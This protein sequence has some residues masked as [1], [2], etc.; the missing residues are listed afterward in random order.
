MAFDLD[1]DY[2]SGKIRRQQR[3]T[4]K[5][6][7]LAGEGALTSL[8]QARKERE[9]QIIQA[10]LDPNYGKAD[11][12]AIRQDKAAAGEAAYAAL[13]GAMAG[14]DNPAAALSEGA[15]I[16]QGASAATAPLARSEATERALVA[17]AANDAA[18]ET[19]KAEHQARVDR[20][21]NTGKGASQGAVVQG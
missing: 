3:K 6:E 4:A 20:W 2:G 1:E 11:E 16:A 19:A 15:T 5:R 12:A 13:S 7:K 21:V 9:K 10:Q 8:R 18:F 14:S 17:K